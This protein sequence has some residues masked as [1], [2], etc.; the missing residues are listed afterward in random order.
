M[1]NIFDP[2]FWAAVIG[3]IF[4][5][6]ATSPRMTLFRAVLTASMAVFFA[7]VFTEA[8]L[9]LTHLDPVVYKLPIAALLTLTG[10][11]VARLL[12]DLSN[13]PDKLLSWLRAWR[14][15]K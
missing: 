7:V 12:I 13:H 15:G 1:N 14:G 10:E 11:G 5:K 9:N 4:V 2:M 8:V 6:L 3:G